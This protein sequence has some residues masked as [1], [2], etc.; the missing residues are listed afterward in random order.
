VIEAAADGRYEF[1][2]RRWPREIDK[3]ITEGIPGEVKD[4]Y[5][6]GRAM[7]RRTARIKVGDAEQ[8]REIPE[9][10]KSVTFTLAVKAGVTHMQTW[11]TGDGGLELGAYYVYARSVG[12]SPE[13]GPASPPCGSYIPSG[14]EFGTSS[15][16]NSS[17]GTHR[18]PPTIRRSD[19]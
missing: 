17:Q 12:L 13:A 7:D 8:T 6:G 2:L 14:G 11:L 19:P 16:R 3:P 10:A 9:G 4:W 1:E 5:T 15:F 18:T